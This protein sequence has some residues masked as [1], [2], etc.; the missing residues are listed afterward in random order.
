MN[1][2]LAVLQEKTRLRLLQLHHTHLEPACNLVC[3]SQSLHDAK[4]PLQAPD[5]AVHALCEDCESSKGKKICHDI[6][7][8]FLTHNMSMT[9]SVVEK[10]KSLLL[11]FSAQYKE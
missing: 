5:N 8:S 3:R 4:R 9:C 6:K 1:P 10:L 2:F 7:R 11:N